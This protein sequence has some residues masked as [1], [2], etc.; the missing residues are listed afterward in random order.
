MDALQGDERNSEM[1]GK[2]PGV[3]DF[4]E[5]FGFGASGLCFAWAFFNFRGL[6][7]R[8]W[9]GFLW[10]SNFRFGVQRTGFS[11]SEIPDVWP[12]LR[13]FKLLALRT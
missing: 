8:P 9:P 13:V 10:I 6:G 5:G 7:L 1:Q 4:M 2:T 3:R 12:E 11:G